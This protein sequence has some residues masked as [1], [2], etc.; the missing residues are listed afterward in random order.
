M[1]PIR[2]NF[3]FEAVQGLM[4][5]Q[6][7]FSQLHTVSPRVGRL[8]LGIQCQDPPF[9]LRHF[10]FHLTA[11]FQ[12]Q[13]VLCVL[14][15]YQRV[16]IKYS[17]AYSW[18][19]IHNLSH[20]Q[21]HACAPALEGLPGLNKLFSFTILEQKYRQRF[22]STLSKLDENLLQDK[23]IISVALHNGQHWIYKLYL[24]SPIFIKI[25]ANKG[26]RFESLLNV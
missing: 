7:S 4:I 15:R 8:N 2:H 13:R 20:L 17:L 5:N 24:P 16:N 1:S 14:F 19:R 26:F 18:R 25:S 12:K 21:T 23:S 10:C 3:L 11:E 22:S 9:S 6:T